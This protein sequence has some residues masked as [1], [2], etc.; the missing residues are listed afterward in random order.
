[1][2]NI[3][4][5][6]FKDWT[7]SLPFEAL[8]FAHILS[9]ILITVGIVLVIVLFKN[10]SQETKSKV[11]DITVS[12]AFGLYIL[13]FFIMP[14]S[15]GEINVDK[16][17]FHICTLMSVMCFLSRHTKFFAQFKSSF[18]LLG[19]IGALMYITYPSG[20]AKGDLLSYRIM[21]TVI[22]HG[23]MIAQGVFA[24]VFSDIKIEWK[25]CYKDLLIIILMS[26]WAVLGNLIYSGGELGD[27]NWFFVV[28]DPFGIFDRSVGAFV[29][30]FV[31]I[32]VIFTMDMLIYSIYFGLRK[33]LV[34]NKL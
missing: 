30:P 31:M 19:L 12:I 17:P 3:F 10:K 4:K 26:V 9:V 20:V 1:M 14:L 24:L 11:V 16:L 22:Y 5:E 25:T 32:V 7:G 8:S 29:M 18:S 6:V 28:Q 27:Y 23:L 13:D 15:N 2:Y 34:K 21:Q 33:L